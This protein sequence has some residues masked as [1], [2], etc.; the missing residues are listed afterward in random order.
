MLRD[1]SFHASRR[2]RWSASSG[3]TG[4]GKST[5]VS[6]VPRFRDTD[7]GTIKID[8]VDICEYQLHP[9]VRQIGFVLQDTVLFRGTVRDNIAFGRPDATEDEISR[10]GQLAN[11]DDSSCAC[12]RATTARSATAGDA[13]PAVSASAS[14]SPAPSSATAR[15]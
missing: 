7:A 10:R 5:V 1:V 6:L 8:G 15:S 11:A 9:F 3:P 4:S 12:P 14:G 13:C 2:A